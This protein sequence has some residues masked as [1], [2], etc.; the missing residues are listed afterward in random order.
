MVHRSLRLLSLLLICA[1]APAVLA[2][3]TDLSSTA[4]SDVTI[5]LTATPLVV[6][7]EEDVTFTMQALNLGKADASN[8]AVHFTLPPTFSLT[9][10]SPACS[11]NPVVTCTKGTL[12][13]SSAATFNVAA[14][15]VDLGTVT[16]TAT[17]TTT[18]PELNG[19][20]KLQ[21]SHPHR[22]RRRNSGRRIDRR[23]RHAVDD[24][25]R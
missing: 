20:N 1:I 15:A 22:R 19:G 25:D 6:N 4:V 8:V 10:T 18:S 24:P 7:A 12:Y 16:A 2:Q 17:I 3:G 23:R 13:A 9:W 5:V 21:W 11:G 14:R